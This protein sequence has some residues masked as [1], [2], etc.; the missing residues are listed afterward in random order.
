MALRE[1]GAFLP[2]YPA[3][4]HRIEGNTFRA[5]ANGMRVLGTGD[6]LSIVRDNDFIDVFHAIGMHPLFRQKSCPLR[7][8]NAS[9]TPGCIVSWSVASVPANA[10]RACRS[11]LRSTPCDRREVDGGMF[12]R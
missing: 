9:H 1:N 8:P 6:D 10:R 7:S 5:A 12:R 4:G 2:P 11:D 3:G